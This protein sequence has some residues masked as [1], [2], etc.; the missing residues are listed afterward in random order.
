[1][2]APLVTPCRFQATDSAIPITKQPAYPGPYSVLDSVRQA[3]QFRKGFA[4]GFGFDG[5]QRAYVLAMNLLLNAGQ[6]FTSDDP[7]DPHRILSLNPAGV[8][9]SEFVKDSPEIDHIK[10]AV[11]GGVPAGSNSYCNARVISLELN[12]RIGNR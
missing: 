12:R 5:K 10:P 7:T 3:G 4:P 1:M 6:R 8:P 9:A 2:S 11:I